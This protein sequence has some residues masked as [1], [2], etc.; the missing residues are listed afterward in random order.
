[1][2]SKDLIK[3]ADQ[4]AN[5]CKVCSVASVNEKG[6]PRICYLSPLRNQGIKEFWFSTGI[7][8]TKVQH[9]KI[10]PKASVSIQ[11]DGDSITLIGKMEIVS[12]PAIKDEL[13]QKWLEKHF[14]NG[15]KDDPD[16]CV[17]HFFSDEG[18]IYINDQFE[19]GQI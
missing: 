2:V 10:N 1:M 19:T 7:S 4:M 11:R 15:G 16:Y 9:F 18:T 13:W 14:P 3:K 12:D 17:V 8:S 6:Y 5:D